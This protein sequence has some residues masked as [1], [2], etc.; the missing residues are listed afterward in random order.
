[1]ATYIIMFIASNILLNIYQWNGQEKSKDKYILFSVFL[2]MIFIGGARYEVG[3]DFSMYEGQYNMLTQYTLNEIIGGHYPLKTEIGYALL[4]YFCYVMSWGFQ[5]VVFI[6]QAITIIF[7][8][9]AINYYCI[10]KYEKYISTLVFMVVYYFST[11]NLIRQSLSMAIYIYISKYIFEKNFKKYI[12]GILIG[13]LFHQSILFMIPL[14]FIDKIK[15]NIKRFI[16]WLIIIVSANKIIINLII[17]LLNLFNSKYMYYFEN[18]INKISSNGEGIGFFGIYN[19]LVFLLA[20]YINSGELKSNRKVR[21]VINMYG[22]YLLINT[23]FVGSELLGRS[24]A[25]FT[26]FGIV[27]VPLITRI[28]NS[29]EKK[30]IFSSITI[31]YYL[32]YFYNLYF[33]VKHPLDMVIPYKFF[34]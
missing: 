24:T 20:M 4:N 32:Y 16:V 6:C 7:I 10:D 1:M 13:S 23:A 9:K 19:I 22:L 26:I 2:I 33:Y 30:L 27:V 29:R 11:F 15:F 17:I 21:I 25:Y 31:F 12:I 28:R 14:Y 3:R 34:I 8:Y 18:E 5:G